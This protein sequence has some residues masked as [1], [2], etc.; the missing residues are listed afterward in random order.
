[1][2]KSEERTR[3]EIEYLETNYMTKLEKLKDEK[4]QIENQYKKEIHNLKVTFFIFYINSI[5]CKYLYAFLYN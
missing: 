3:Q 4:E 2:M 1:M 5:I